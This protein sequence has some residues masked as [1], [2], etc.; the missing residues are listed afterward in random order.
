MDSITTAILAALPAVTSDIVKTSVKDAYDALK[1]VIRGKWGH[2]SGVT[3]A[4]ESLEAN[5]SSTDRAAV[6]AQ[7][8]AAAHADEDTDVREALVRLVAELKNRESELAHDNI[9][10]NVTGGHIEGFV[11][12]SHLSI[13]SVS[14]GAGAGK[15]KP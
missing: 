13:E 4:I 14:F 3:Q 1:A 15:R 9:R 10:V 7:N 8:V 5:P 6:L 11:G 2:E 12:V